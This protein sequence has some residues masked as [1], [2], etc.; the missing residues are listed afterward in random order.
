MSHAK[1]E[2]AAAGRQ[3]YSATKECHGSVGYDWLRHLVELGPKK[4]KDEL[5]R[6]RKA[7][8]ALP[9]VEEIASRAHPQVVS[10]V[11][12]F[13]L[14]AAALN[15][16]AAKGIV[17]WDVADINAAIIACMSRRLQQR[18]NIDTAGELLREIKLRRQIIA[19]TYKTIAL[20]A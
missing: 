11:N 7:W 14:I 9:Q 16:A 2:I 1:D 12:R 15:M 8:L 3:Y 18:G 13:A 19:T 4:I 17:P 5:K 10:V 6:L 20:S